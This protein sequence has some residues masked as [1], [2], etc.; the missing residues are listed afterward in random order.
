[1]V[2]KKE[3]FCVQRFVMVVE[4]AAL[5]CFSCLS[6]YT[7]SGSLQKVQLQAFYQNIYSEYG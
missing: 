1:M 2:L 4:H 3:I 7:S 5:Q 6:V